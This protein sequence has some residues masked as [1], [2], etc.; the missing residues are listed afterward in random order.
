MKRLIPLP[1][2]DCAEKLKVVADPTRLSVLEILLEGP[3]RVGE[4]NALLGIEQTLLSHH[5]KVLREAGLV[6]AARAG[7]AVV[8]RLAQHVEVAHTGRALNLGCCRLS[9]D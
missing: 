5:L 4:I 3:K 9:F 7:K 6:E 8:Y 2:I 1:D